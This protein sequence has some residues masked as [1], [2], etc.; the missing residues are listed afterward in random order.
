[1]RYRV[2]PPYSHAHMTQ[3]EAEAFMCAWHRVVASDGSTVAYVPD[4][5]TARIVAEAMERAT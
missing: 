2:E 4:H 1:M 5:V 3:A